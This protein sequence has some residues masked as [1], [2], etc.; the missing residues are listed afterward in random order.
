V[1]RGQPGQEMAVPES[2]E[3]EHGARALIVGGEGIG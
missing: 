2:D 3:A 1:Q